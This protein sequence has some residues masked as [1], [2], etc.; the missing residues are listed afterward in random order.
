MTKRIERRIVDGRIECRSNADG[1][2]GVRGYAAVFDSVAH[3]E[4]VRRSAFTRTLAQQDDIKFL[5]NHDGVPLASTRAG[6]MT[7]GTDNIGLWFDVPAL[8]VERN[9]RA[10]EFASAVSRGDMYQC[11][12]AGYFLDKETIAGTSE[13]REVQL[14][15]VSGVTYPWYDE[16]SMQITGDRKLDKQLVSARSIPTEQRLE[17]VLAAVR[18]APPGKESYGDLAAE[19]TEA[20]TELY[21][22]LMV[23]DLGDDWCVYELW[24][25]GDW[26]CYQIG[27]MMSADG[28]VQFDTPFEVEAITEYRPLTMEEQQEETAEDSGRSYTIAEARALLMS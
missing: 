20:L 3:G 23:C 18:A 12:F 13:V 8:D 14:V 4:V 15:D 7:V 26:D 19:L 21:G 27:Y 2:Q 1:T 5:V 28:S 9:P 22:V 24:C 17:L 11:S 10:A 16:T 6:T 25:D